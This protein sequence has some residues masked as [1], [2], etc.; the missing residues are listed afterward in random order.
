MGDTTRVG[1]GRQT[2][3]GREVDDGMVGV[4]RSQ[5]LILSRDEALDD[6]FLYCGESHSQRERTGVRG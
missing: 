6:D 1:E 4:S 2:P 3:G 5:T